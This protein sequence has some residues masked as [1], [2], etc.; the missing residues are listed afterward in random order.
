MPTF[1]QTKFRKR[2][3]KVKSPS[4]QQRRREALERRKTWVQRLK[5]F[6]NNFVG[7]RRGLIFPNA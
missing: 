5:K 7:F 3:R 6:W 2:K 1:Q 4:S